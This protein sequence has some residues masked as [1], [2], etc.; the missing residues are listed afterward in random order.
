L[1]K[2]TAADINRLYAAFISDPIAQAD[3]FWSALRDWAFRCSYSIPAALKDDLVQNILVS[4]L[5]SLPTFKPGCDF[6]KWANGVIRN[7]RFDAY[8]RLYASQDEPISQMGSWQEDG[9]FI[10]FDPAEWLERLDDADM[11]LDEEREAAASVKLDSIRA[12]LKKPADLALFDILRAGKS[13]RD[14]A[15]ILGQPYRTV[16]TR[17]RS[18]QK[19]VESK[20]NPCIQFPERNTVREFKAA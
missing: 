17:L 8:R 11:V 9:S 13:M 5:E 19:K 14:A 12:S 1:H 16:Q 2:L 18:W 6:T 3:P 15:D 4:I 10:E 20:T 7:E